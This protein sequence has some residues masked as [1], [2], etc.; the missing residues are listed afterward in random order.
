MIKQTQLAQAAQYAL[1]AWEGWN[2]LGVTGRAH[3][4]QHFVSQLD[5]DLS[6]IAQ[7]QINQALR[8]IDAE[9]ELPG[10]TGESNLLATGGRGLFIIA[11]DQ[12]ASETAMVGQLVAALISGNVVL[13]AP[14]PSQNGFCHDLLSQLIADS[15]PAAVVQLL[16]GLTSVLEL[17]LC[18]SLA[19]IACLCDDATARELNRRLASRDGVLVQ[20]IAETD[21][22]RLPLI[23]SEQ[24]LYRFITERVCTTNTTAVGGNATLLELG[25]HS[26]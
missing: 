3:L 9:Q 17:A 7:W 1:T 4:L 21:P 11:S 19:G 16:E 20:L 24:Y 22:V 13:L 10:P 26:D 14:H 8:L 6:S 18:P 23:G 2:G 15:C 25:S 12:E 5:H